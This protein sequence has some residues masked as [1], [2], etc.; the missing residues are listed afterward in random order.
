MSKRAI[1]IGPDKDSCMHF[2]DRYPGTTICREQQCQVSITK[3]EEAGSDT[4]KG[5]LNTAFQALGSCIRHGSGK[6]RSAVRGRWICQAHSNR[7]PL[8]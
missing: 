2:D 1:Y 8:A 6:N 4:F 7:M 3:N 5:L